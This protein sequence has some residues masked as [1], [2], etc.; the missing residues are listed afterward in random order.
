M[1]VRP[2]AHTP[3]R[4]DFHRCLRCHPEGIFSPLGCGWRWRRFRFPLPPTTL[5]KFGCQICAK[6]KILLSVDDPEVNESHFF[7]FETRMRIS[8]IQSRTSRRD[9]NFLTLNLGLRDE[10]EKN[11]PS[12][13][14]IETRSR[15]IIFILRLRDENENSFDLISVFETRTRVA[16]FH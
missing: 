9:E 14:D 6:H 15:F 7:N 10:I 3:L 4:G 1:L 16:N 13:S 12:I 11:S 2:N 8:S 5:G